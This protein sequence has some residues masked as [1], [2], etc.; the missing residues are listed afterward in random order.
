MKVKIE[1]YTKCFNCLYETPNSKTLVWDNGDNNPQVEDLELSDED[2]GI[3]LN[4]LHGINRIVCENCQ[5]NEKLAFAVVK[6]NDKVYNEFEDSNAVENNDFLIHNEILEFA[7]S[8][9]ILFNMKDGSHK[10]AK[11][12]GVMT[13]QMDGSKSYTAKVFFESDNLNEIFEF[14]FDRAISYEYISLRDIESVEFFANIEDVD[15]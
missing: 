13:N 2:L 9:I 6:V 3:M 10:I 7:D 14:D 11:I 8:S 4:Q 12:D 15:S 5:T 1:F